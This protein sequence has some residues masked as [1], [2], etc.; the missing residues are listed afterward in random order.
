MLFFT[1]LKVIV[2]HLSDK[3]KGAKLPIFQK[4]IKVLTSRTF[5]FSARFISSITIVII[6]EME[7]LNSLPWASRRTIGELRKS[8]K[9]NA[10][11]IFK[12]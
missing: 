5:V 8:Q 12:P 11:R 6:A 2:N 7:V 3:K 10:L 4:L 9:I 1:R